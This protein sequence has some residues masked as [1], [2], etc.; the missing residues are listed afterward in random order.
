MI[1]M[2]GREMPKKK[3]IYFSTGNL[4]IRESFR[5]T[6]CVFTCHHDT[7][8]NSG[9]LSGGDE[10]EREIDQRNQWM[11]ELFL[12][13]THFTGLR[14]TSSVCICTCVPVCVLDQWTNLLKV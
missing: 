6:T 12:A 4:S 1:K 11:Q 7:G 10:L 2:G 13:W 14:H 9:A 5:D 8:G 3:L